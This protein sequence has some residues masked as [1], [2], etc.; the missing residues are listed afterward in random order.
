MLDGLEET[1]QMVFAKRA[2]WFT[3]NMLDGI[4]KTCWMVGR[5][6]Y[7]ME[8]LNHLDGRVAPCYMVE[9]LLSGMYF[10][11]AE[12]ISLEPLQMAMQHQLSI[13]YPH[14]WLDAL[15]IT[16]QSFEE[17]ARMA[18]AVKLFEMK[19]LSSGMA[20]NLAGTSRVLFLLHLHRFRVPMID[21]EP[22]ELVEDI[23]N[24]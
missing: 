21:I 20:A 3:G 19:R 2:R 4:S 8:R 23:R 14:N 16:Q 17:E 22:D 5:I 18:M 7:S 11:S 15:Q 24:A 13:Q 1:C 6:P 9:S 10:P 12:P